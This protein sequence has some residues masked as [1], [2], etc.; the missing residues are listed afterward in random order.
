MFVPTDFLDLG[1]RA[2]VDIVL[3]RL[4]GKGTIRRLARWVYDFPKEHPVLGPLQ[5]S[6]EVVARA[7]ALRWEGGHLASFDVLM[8]VAVLRIT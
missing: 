8:S 2:A 3:H 7:L 1:S 5:P 6:A 4:T